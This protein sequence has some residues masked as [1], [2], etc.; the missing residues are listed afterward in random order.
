MATQSSTSRSESIST[1]GW[2]KGIFVVKVIIDKEVLTEKV[3]VK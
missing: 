1:V 3:I 2:P